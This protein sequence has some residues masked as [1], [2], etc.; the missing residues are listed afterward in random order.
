M[1][2]GRK[3]TYVTFLPGKIGGPV[4]IASGQSVLA[5]QW[6]QDYWTFSEGPSA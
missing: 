2:V 3:E 5:E 1:G 4:T 6:I